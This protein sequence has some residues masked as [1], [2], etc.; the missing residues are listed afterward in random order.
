MSDGDADSAGSDGEERRTKEVPTKRSPEL[1]WEQTEILEDTRTTRQRTKHVAGLRQGLDPAEDPV[2]GLFLRF[3]P[4]SFF[5]ASLTK[6]A[7]HYNAQ[8]GRH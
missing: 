6:V 7:A 3:F 8:G 4:V 1:D 2:L 5:T